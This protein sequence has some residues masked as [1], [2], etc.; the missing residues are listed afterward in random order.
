LRL[1][2]E[3]TAFRRYFALRSRKPFDNL[4]TLPREC[5]KSFCLAY[6][7]ALDWLEKDQRI[8]SFLEVNAEAVLITAKF[9]ASS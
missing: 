2:D 9:E 1:E 8:S 7:Y 4:G 6:N 5:G 3:S